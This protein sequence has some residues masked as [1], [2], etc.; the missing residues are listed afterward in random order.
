[1]KKNQSFINTEDEIGEL[2]E[3]DNIFN[4]KQKELIK[5]ENDKSINVD[6]SYDDEHSKSSTLRKNNKDLF[7]YIKDNNE[8]EII[9][10]IDSKIQNYF[11]INNNN[12]NDILNSFNSKN[13]NNINN[14]NNFIITNFSHF[15]IGNYSINQSY[16]SFGLNQSKEMKILENKY[17]E[18]MN[19][20]NTILNL[21]EYWQNF[22]LEIVK[23]VST[24]LKNNSNLQ[25]DDLLNEQFKL[26]VIEDV[27][28]LV[29]FSQQNFNNFNYQN[30]IFEIEKFNIVKENN[31][32]INNIKKFYDNFEII[33]EIY[34]DI[35]ENNIY[36]NKYNKKLLLSK[37][38]NYNFEKNFNLDSINFEQKNIINNKFYLEDDELDDLPP[39]IFNKQNKTI[40]L[41]Q[42]NIQNFIIKPIKKNNKKNNFS[43]RSDNKIVNTYFEITNSYNIKKSKTNYQISNEKET[44]TVLTIKNIN[45]LETINNEISNQ[46]NIIEKDKQKLKLSY[47]QQITDLTNEINL[48]KLNNINNN[49]Q[50]T[51]DILST[52]ILNKSTSNINVSINQFL[53]E[54]IPPEQ[55]YKIFSHCIKH[56]KYEEEIYK[57]F[58]EEEDLIYLKNFVKKMEKFFKFSS[59]PFKINNFEPIHYYRPIE[60]ATQK[61]YKEN[62]LNGVKP[63]TYTNFSRSTSKKKNDL[64]ENK[65]HSINLGNNNNSTFNKYKAVLRSLK[66]NK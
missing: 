30:K 38:E 59:M 50:D 52:T 41:K 29:N 33:N 18:L 61:K 15:I 27:K 28:N 42:Q 22:Y 53:P 25:L 46:L 6:I 45:N 31:L 34:F 17:V 55:T 3:E 19:N 40:N 9:I 60:S 23:L 26:T 54:M 48:L 58:M 7:K 14:E 10:P 66:L 56:F 11:N 2:H 39:I 5:V 65:N 43:F 44:M 62:I 36:N 4:L 64:F 1:M 20:Y 16:P 13:N 51:K 8:S 32:F 57:E 12:N 35:I 47:E 63:L 21:M 49:T 37:N 24:Q